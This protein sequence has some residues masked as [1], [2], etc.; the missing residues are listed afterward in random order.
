MLG[1]LLAMPCIGRPR[2]GST[3]PERCPA[4]EGYLRHGPRLGLDALV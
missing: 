2:C 4:L 1:T 3:A